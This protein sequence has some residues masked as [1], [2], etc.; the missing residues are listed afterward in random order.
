[1]KQNKWTLGINAILL[2]I[3]AGCSADEPLEKVQTDGRVE[4][5]VSSG[6]SSSVEPLSRT[7]LDGMINTAFTSDL[8]V[9]FARTD[10][11]DAAAATYGNYE[12]NALVGSVNGSTKEL[13]FAP[14]AYYLANSNKTKL[15]GWYPRR[16]GVTFASSGDGGTVSFGE[17]DG[18]TDI[19]V[20]T[21][22][23]GNKNTPI[24]SFRF[25]HLLT[26]I[27]VK[28]YAVNADIKTLWGAVNT[29]K[30]TG[31]KQPCTLTLP[32]VSSADDSGVTPVFGTSTGDLT[33]VPQQPDDNT[34]ITW[35]IDLGVGTDNAVT[36][37]YAMF[38][39]VAAGGSI[40][41]QIDLA[42]GGLQ[43]KTI[44]APATDGFKPGYSYEIT[45]KFTS[46]GITPT[47]S[48]KDWETGDPITDVVI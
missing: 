24:S 20:T 44:S 14:V 3:F 21:L 18:K 2:L 38:A 47:V 16:D 7:V 5:R 46:A 23:E 40:E 28:A 32:V 36:T 39:P 10:A 30:I 22:K 29:V 43:K 42:D 31:K 45:L 4:I 27:C 26:Q 1:M 17:I 11:T 6:I 48:I 19:M 13:S 33:L 41:L 9:A 15:V 34:A 37:G 8:D 25:S 12:T 35:P